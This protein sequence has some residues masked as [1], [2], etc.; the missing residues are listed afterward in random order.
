MPLVNLPDGTQAS[1]PDTMSHDAIA[2]VIKDHLSSKSDTGTVE[3]GN[4]KPDYSYAKSALG[5]LAQGGNDIIQGA[6]NVPTYVMQHLG[7]ISPATADKL[8][9]ATDQMAKLDA[10]I[11]TD[12]PSVAKIAKTGVDLAALTA[13]MKYLPGLADVA[14]STT[15]TG[16]VGRGAAMAGGQALLGAG[17]GDYNAI[18]QNATLNAEASPLL[19]GIGYGL[20]TLGS[21]Q[22]AV[23]KI[24]DLL[25]TSKATKQTAY[26]A[27]ENAPFTQA[28]ATAHQMTANNINQYLQ[29]NA[30][31]L[32]Q[33]QI[34]VLSDASHGLATASNNADALKVFQQ[35]NGKTGSFSGSNASNSLYDTYS[36]IK[37]QI[38]SDLTNSTANAGMPDAMNTAHNALV[39]NSTLSNTFKSLTDDSSS[40]NPGAATT[41]L[42]TTIN[43]LKNN[44]N[45]S[46]AVEVLQGAAKLTNHLATSP[47][48]ITGMESHI[49]GAAI[50]GGAGYAEGGTTG[51]ELG[52]ASGFVGGRIVLQGIADLANTSAG[53][54]ILRGLNKPGTTTKDL[55][56]VTRSIVAA[57][58]AKSTANNNQGN[59]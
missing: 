12:H 59:Q 24:N 28:D 50:G 43:S 9:H 14:S 16:A 49:L 30:D 58:I 11:T 27:V 34:N 2:G 52:A 54:S 41:K 46:D 23:D 17:S 53:K 47:F 42:N 35:L 5:G 33:Q 32:T 25:T 39:V 57:T 48:K 29:Q 22:A 3:D 4:L 56:A 26:K 10:S 44:P 19:Q 37:D 1:F 7:I 31:K 40:L 38:K 8:S 15:A 36:G 18:P 55:Q 20:G 51:G 6:I 21:K 45:M 13:G